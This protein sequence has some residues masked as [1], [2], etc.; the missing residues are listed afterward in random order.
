MNKVQQFVDIA[1]HT[2]RCDK[3]YHAQSSDQF[4]QRLGNMIQAYMDN[5]WSMAVQAGK[6]APLGCADP[7]GMADFT[8][9]NFGLGDSRK[10]IVAVAPKGTDVD[11]FWLWQKMDD[12]EFLSKEDAYAYKE[13]QLPSKY[14]N[15]WLGIVPL[16]YLAVGL[17]E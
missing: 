5:N 1:M 12:K 15:S 3:C 6:T 11:D 16:S 9:H 17:D 10:W 14:Q 8:K 2:N 7:D 13:K 4:C